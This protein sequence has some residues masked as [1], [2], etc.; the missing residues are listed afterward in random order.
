MADHETPFPELLERFSS[1]GKADRK[2]VLESFSI[3]ERAAFE[4]AVEEEE[5]EQVAEAERQRQADRQYLGYSP[6]LAHIVEASVAGDQSEL[7]PKIAG[8]LAT[9]HKAMI[10]A[11]GIEPRQGWRGTLDRF[12][13]ALGFAGDTAR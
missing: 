11:Q 12:T 10:A 4:K 6:W 8:A 13:E 7:T 3:E 9:E 5:A 2:A 1:L